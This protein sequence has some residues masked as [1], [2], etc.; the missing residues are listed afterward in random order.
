M[1]P[2]V[3]VQ[4]RGPASDGVLIAGCEISVL[5]INEKILGLAAAFE[6][7]FCPVVTLTHC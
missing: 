5:V 6:I 1:G 2:R 4:R 7:L 3:S